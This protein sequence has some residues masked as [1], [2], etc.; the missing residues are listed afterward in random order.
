MSNR[1]APNET[2][3]KYRVA[4]V[5]LRIIAYECMYSTE[6]EMHVP[7][8]KVAYLTLTLHTNRRRS[9]KLAGP[10]E[11]SEILLRM[12]VFYSAW[13]TSTSTVSLHCQSFRREIPQL[14]VFEKAWTLLQSA[15]LSGSNIA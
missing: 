11:N 15:A 4:V 10:S 7:A 12:L 14:I 1:E 6:E 13:L 9:S 2:Q 8:L 3:T 5:A